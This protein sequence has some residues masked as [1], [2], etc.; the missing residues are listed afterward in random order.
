MPASEIIAI[1]ALSTIGP[2]IPLREATQRRTRLTLL[3]RLPDNH[4]A[5]TAGHALIDPFAKIP[6][7]LRRTLT[8]DHHYELFHHE[9]IERATACGSAE[10][11]IGTRAHVYSRDPWAPGPVVSRHH[12]RAGTCSISSSK[13]MSPHL[14]VIIVSLRRVAIT[15]ATS[16]L[17]SQTRRCFDWP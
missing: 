5:Q 11:T 15:C 4:C 8:C 3:V 14:L 7:R 2:A 1:N 17:S 10:R 16:W 13:R 9:R 6:A 12:D